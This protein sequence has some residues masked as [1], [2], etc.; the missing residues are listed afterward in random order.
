MGTGGEC[1]QGH[2]DNHSAYPFVLIVFRVV[3]LI[4]VCGGAIQKPL[5]ILF[6]SYFQVGCRVG[7][8]I[9]VYPQVNSQIIGLLLNRHPFIHRLC[10]VKA[11]S[12]TMQAFWLPHVGTGE[13]KPP[14]DRAERFARRTQNHGG[15]LLPL[16]LVSR[17]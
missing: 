8:C 4:L 17:R 14:P 6:F 1:A 5:L 11:H 16:Q 2:R 13:A 15:L 7:N 10:S 3:S 12:N 9:L